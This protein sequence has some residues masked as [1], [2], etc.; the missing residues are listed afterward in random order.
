MGIVAMEKPVFM[1]HCE[2]MKEWDGKTIMLTVNWRIIFDNERVHW[3]MC[4]PEGFISDGGSIPRFFH[5]IWTPLGYYLPCYLPHDGLYAGELVP[6]AEADYI[7]LE[8]LQD[9]GAC[10]AD[11]NAQYS[12]VRAGGGFVWDRHVPED[13]AKVRASIFWEYEVKHA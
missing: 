6:R 12:G 1:P 11:R 13:V 8:L 5:R 10:W 2:N 9:M 3:E 7:L 4:L